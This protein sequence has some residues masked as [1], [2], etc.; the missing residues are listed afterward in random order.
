MGAMGNDKAAARAL[1]DRVHALVNGGDTSRAATEALRA[2]GP[3][4]LGFLSGVLRNDAD[5]DDVFAAVSER[6]WRSFETFDWRCSLR[7]WSHVIAAREI[8]RFRRGDRRHVEGRVPISE[9]ADVIAA[10]RTGTSS[11]QRSEH[12]RA[13]T[14]LRDELPEEDRMLLVLRVDRNLP[15]D[16]IALAFAEDPEQCSDEAR[17]R[18]AARLRQRFQILK[19]RLAGRARDAGLLPE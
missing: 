5:A 10:V 7:T 6:L 18:E 19:R 8:M 13:V 12:Q 4:I 1:D 16:E 2:L 14:R 9:V 15:Y 11:R 3:D 17:K